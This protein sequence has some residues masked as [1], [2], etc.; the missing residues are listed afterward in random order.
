M[1]LNKKKTAVNNSAV[2]RAKLYKVIL[3]L[4]MDVF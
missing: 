2:H 3:L 4:K 1:I